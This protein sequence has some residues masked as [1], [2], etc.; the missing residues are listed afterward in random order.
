MGKGLLDRILE[1]GGR[2]PDEGQKVVRL[3]DLN[4][5][6]SRLDA[7]KAYSLAAIGYLEARYSPFAQ[8]YAAIDGPQALCLYLRGTHGNTLFAMGET[9]GLA[10]ILRT[11]PGPRNT[12]MIY[13]PNHLPALQQHYLL[14]KRQRLARM[15]VDRESFRPVGSEQ[16][17]PLKPEDVGQLNS[18]YAS[19]G[20]G[21]FTQQYIGSGVYYGIWKDGAL[22]SVAGTQSIS[23]AYGVAIVANVLT[24][25]K[26][27]G[28]GY[29]TACT[30]AVTAKL[31][32]RC[33]T[34]GLNV[35]PG[36]TPAIR[37]YSKLGYRMADSL[38]EAWGLRKDGMVGMIMKL[39]AK[40]FNSKGS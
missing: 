1:T 7:S 30:S 14:Q 4:Q 3:T 34:V 6:L 28:H 24:N 2:G 9:D 39:L 15:V 37:A 16:A 36:N 26:H 11:Y 25:P 17:Q 13:E 29:A 35:E 12:Y 10:A 40:I 32:E 22:V 21:W 8:W 23:E 27:R 19:E 33:K 20:G 31:L 38:E 5:V 18:L